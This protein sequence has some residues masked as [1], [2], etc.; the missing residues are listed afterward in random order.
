MPERGIEL[1]DIVAQLVADARRQEGLSMDELADRA[2]VHRTYIGL[3]ERRS[4]Q[5]TLAVAANLAEA[6][7]LTL[8][9]LVERAEQDVAY[10]VVGDIDLP[11]R[12]LG[13]HADH[14]RLGDGEQL[15]D[16]SQLT[17]A[18]I[19]R[20]ID[21]TYRRLDLIDGQ[22]RESG[23]PS[24]ARLVELTPA[25]AARGEPA[26]RERRPGPRTGS[27]SSMDPTTLPSSCLCAR[28]S[29]SSRSCRPW[30]RTALPAVPRPTAST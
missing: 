11:L 27:T 29:P 7:G 2:G 18:M 30:R 9:E 1:S 14:E 4:R 28:A 12:G 20:A 22:M 16:I 8:S 13:R 3:L 6:L 15:A 25:L 5:P 23:S 26:Q 17:P 21:L 19:G 24:I 10:G